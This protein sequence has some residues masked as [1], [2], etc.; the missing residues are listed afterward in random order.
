MTLSVGLMLL[1]CAIKIPSLSLCGVRVSACMVALLQEAQAPV[2]LLL[3][4]P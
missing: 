2:V 4:L 1:L 3:C